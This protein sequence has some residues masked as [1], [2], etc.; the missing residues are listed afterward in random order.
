M[1]PELF[2][3][4]VNILC[5]TDDEGR[6]PPLEVLA[7]SGRTQPKVMQKILD[8]LVSERLVDVVDKCY[9]AHNWAKFQYDSDVSTVRVKRFR[10]RSKNVSET[11]PDTDTDT[12]T[13]KKK[14]RVEARE[15]VRAAKKHGTRWPSD[16]I[17]PDD[18]LEVGAESRK[19]VNLPPIDLRAEALR[20]ANY[21]AS[22]SGG[23][24]TKLDWKRTWI[25]WCLTEKGSRNGNGT[26]NGQHGP[27]STAGEVFGNLYATARAQREA[28]GE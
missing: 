7:F 4:W 22:K 24:A 11:R 27:T 8:R 21:W 16:A 28:S 2:K 26:S 1:R 19:S 23:S 15:Q 13:E 6:L 12:D 20:F 18:W 5:Q 10:E 17:I 25:N 3:H 9:F 14:E